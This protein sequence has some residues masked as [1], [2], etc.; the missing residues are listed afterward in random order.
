VSD[1]LILRSINEMDDETWEPLYW[2]SVYGWVGIEEATKYTEEDAQLFLNLP[3]GAEWKY[4]SMELGID[5]PT[6]EDT[7]E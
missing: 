1:K 3:C 4:E 7:D 5:I 6:S 2:S